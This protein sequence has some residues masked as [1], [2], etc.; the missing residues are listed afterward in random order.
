MTAAIASPS[1]KTL[2]RSDSGTSGGVQG[3]R[4][5]A[6]PEA[7]I[8]SGVFFSLRV[9]SIS[10]VMAFSNL[11]SLMRTRAKWSRAA[12]LDEDEGQVEPRGAGKVGALLESQLLRLEQALQRRSVIPEMVFTESGHDPG[13]GLVRL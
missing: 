7:T 4:N 9:S 11:L 13:G 2:S 5:P 6:I 1:L 3:L 10:V 8:L 12:R